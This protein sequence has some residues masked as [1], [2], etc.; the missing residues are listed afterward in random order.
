MLNGCTCVYEGMSAS[1]RATENRS[2]VSILTLVTNCFLHHCWFLF[3]KRSCSKLQ[4]EKICLLWML[5]HLDSVLSESCV[6]ICC[7]DDKSTCLRSE[8]ARPPVLIRARDDQSGCPPLMSRDK[9][10]QIICLFWQIRLRVNR[11]AYEWFHKLARVNYGI[12]GNPTQRCYHLFRNIPC[13]KKGGEHP[14][15]SLILTG[16]IS[17]HSH[18]RLLHAQVG[19][20]DRNRP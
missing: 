5:P 7:G 6:Y 17:K 20:L 16:A 1:K 4:S 18:V 9:S 3:W 19:L 2:H 14:A 15:A 10:A 8:R 12:R 13:I 11:V